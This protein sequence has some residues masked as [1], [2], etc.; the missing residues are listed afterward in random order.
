MSSSMQ[1]GLEKSVFSTENP[2]LRFRA[3]FIPSRA[4]SVFWICVSRRAFAS[5]VVLSFPEI[6]ATSI[7]RFAS[8]S[9]LSI[10]F[11]ESLALD[12]WFSASSLALLCFSDAALESSLFHSSRLCSAPDCLSSSALVSPHE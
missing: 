8:W 4:V 2:S 6:L 12:F 5:P 1:M 10:V 3:F 11:L 9:W 7:L